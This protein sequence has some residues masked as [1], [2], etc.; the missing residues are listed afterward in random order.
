MQI[1]YLKLTL[2]RGIEQAEMRIYPNLHYA[3]PRPRRHEK[4]MHLNVSRAISELEGETFNMSPL[5]THGLRN[6]D[7]NQCSRGCLDYAN[8]TGATILSDIRLP[9]T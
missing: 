1:A 6:T 5:K 7:L 3:R 4:L 9:R 2:G 8:L